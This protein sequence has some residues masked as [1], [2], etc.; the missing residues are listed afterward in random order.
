MIR[1]VSGVIVFAVA[2]FFAVS[3]FAEELKIAYV[4]L[5]KVFNEY[6]GTKVAQ[7]NLEE[8]E[9]KR[10]VEFRAITEE[11]RNLQKEAE[12]LKEKEKQEKER[13]ILQ[14]IGEQRNFRVK[15]EQELIGM[16]NKVYAEIM[17]K[18]E[19]VVKEKAEKEGYSLIF[20]DRALIF[21]KPGY[22]ITDKIIKIIN[23]KKD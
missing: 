3:T 8:E 14:K 23:E 10:E 9:K 4:N 19:A 15:V 17:Q 20:Q 16:R 12:L 18:I 22:N 1:F 6:H 2:C 5:E 13:L 7:G 11:I 21:K